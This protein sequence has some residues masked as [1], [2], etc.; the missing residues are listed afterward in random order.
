MNLLS[1][2]WAYIQLTNPLEENNNG[3]NK[4]QNSSIMTKWALQS[5]K[6]DVK[7]FQSFN[8]FFFLLLFVQVTFLS[9]SLFLITT[10]SPL[11]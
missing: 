3:I 11:I 5:L 2:F 7:Q 6:L 4:S 8:T 9:T 10:L 1:V